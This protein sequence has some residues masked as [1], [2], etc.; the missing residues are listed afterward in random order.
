M[1]KTVVRGHGTLP[2]S[3]GPRATA[4]SAQPVGGIQGRWTLLPVITRAFMPGS[5]LPGRQT[6]YMSWL[7]S[8]HHTTQQLKCVLTALVQQSQAFAKVLSSTQYRCFAVLGYACIQHVFHRALEHRRSTEHELLLLQSPEMANPACK[9]WLDGSKARADTDRSDRPLR[10][11]LV[12]TSLSCQ[13]PICA[14]VS[15]IIVTLQSQSSMYVKNP[16]RHPAASC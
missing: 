16:W 2:Q 5:L 15:F 8:R 12:R 3:S 11:V 6:Y 13:L 7:V 4:C 14:S 10:C 9:V 1:V